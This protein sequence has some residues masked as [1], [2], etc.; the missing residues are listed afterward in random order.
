MDMNGAYEAEM[1]A[2]C[3]QAEVV[4]DLFHVVAK[5][6]HEVIDRVRVDEANRLK[7]D[8]AARKV[9]EGLTLVALAQPG[10]HQARRRPGAT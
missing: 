6:G 4:F 2:Q 3:P 9:D 10:Q 1:R 7:H 8:K 5:Y